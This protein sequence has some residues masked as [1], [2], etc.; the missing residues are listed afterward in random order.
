MIR[1]SRL[2]DYGVVLM[3]SMAGQPNKLHRAGEVASE[4]HL[5]LPTVSKLLRRLTR[6]GLLVS[7]R[8]TKGGY[9]LV[10]P[11]E[12]ISLADIISALEGPIALTLCTGTGL[13]ECEHEQR[14][15]VRTRWQRINQVFRQ[16]LGSV[17]LSDMVA[18][19]D[20]PAKEEE[21]D[22]IGPMR[23][24]VAQGFRVLQPAQG[25]R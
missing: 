19:A 10:R 12:R 14:C 18:S 20:S 24:E 25:A 16:A 5:P 4:V 2:T 3:S 21:R 17:A 7:H 8:G 6:R 23:R 13:A 9:S 22:M 1:V 11:P 15:P